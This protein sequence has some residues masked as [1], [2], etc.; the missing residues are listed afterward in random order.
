[1]GAQRNPASH[2]AILDAA[3]QLLR[4]EGLARFSIEAVARRACAGKP[5]IYRWWPNKASLLLEVYARIKEG[6]VDPDTGSLEGD[7]AGFLKNL[8]TFWSSTDAGI[9]FRSVIA[10]S[11][12][13]PEAQKA[14]VAY[15]LDRRAHT[16]RLFA[17]AR[18][19]HRPLSDEQ[20]A[21][22]AE[23]VASTALLRLL[24]D[25]LEVDG[26]ELA[27]LAKQLVEG[28]RP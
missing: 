23:V 13:D 8:L 6:L 5:T 17:K 11:Q 3:Q 16:A 15:H 1:M 14:F 2:Q 25:R 7:V 9:L 28:V 10:E 26:A 12:N 18:S 4:E 22:L 19:G 27:F 20:A 21:V 24:T